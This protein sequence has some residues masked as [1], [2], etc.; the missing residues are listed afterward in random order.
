MARNKGSANLAASLE[1]LAGAPLDAREVVQAKAD[2]TAN[3]SFPYKY[4]GMEVYVVA[5]NIKYRLIG[6]D[7]TVLANWQEVGSGG[8]KTIQVEELP[9]ASAALEGVIYQYIGADDDPLVNG[10]FYKCVSDG[11]V[12]PTYSWVQT[13]T[14]PTDANTFCGTMAEW[15]NL[16]PTEQNKYDFVDILGDEQYINLGLYIAKYSTMPEAEDHVGEIVFYVG[17][18]T[19]D[20]TQNRFYKSVSDEN[21]P[22][23]YSWELVDVQDS[24]Q[25]TA[26]PTASADNL[27]KVFQYIGPDDALNN[28]THN[29]FY[30]CVSDGEVEPTYSWAQKNVQPG[31]SG[32]GSTTKS[33]TA[34]IEVGGIS[35]G[36]NYP[37]DTPIENIISDLLEPTLYPTLTAPS[38]SISYNSATYYA[39]GATVASMAATVA[40]NRGS[41]NPAYGTSGKRSGAATGFAIATSGADTEYSDSSDSSGSFTVPALTRST[42]GNIVVTGTA[43]YDAG[44]QP[45]DSK[46][47][48]YQTPLAAGSVTATKTL[49]FIQ[50]YYYG[51]SNSSTISDFTG[52]TESVTAKGQKT[53][54]YTT[55]NQYM[56]FAYDSAYGNLKTILDGNGFDVTGG[57]TKNTVTVNGFSYFVYIANSPTTDTNAPFTFKY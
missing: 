11:E 47:G 42:K 55:A 21:D 7:P 52:L 26:L 57:W 16:T 25:V 32:G 8:G 22:P 33:I 27:G 5:E 6:N 56:V 49:Q 12:T 4:I 50:P 41:I 54:N 51:A 38:A 14:Q 9:E 24:I 48:D 34:A 37:I 19:A 3:D 39:V 2:L 40:L 15:E 13:D 45:K 46:G 36:T 31:S 23:T 1:V 30:E 20:Y 29:F 43:S 35:A 10:Y 28:L 53:F 17:G 18:S 44:E